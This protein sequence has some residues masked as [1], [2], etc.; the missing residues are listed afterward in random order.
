MTTTRQIFWRSLGRMKPNYSKDFSTS[1]DSY[2]PTP[3]LPL[4]AARLDWNLLRLLQNFTGYHFS[5]AGLRSWAGSKIVGNI[6]LITDTQLLL[7][8][9]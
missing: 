9:T 4:P 2:P 8:P 3:A 7:M 5:D 6:I 1:I